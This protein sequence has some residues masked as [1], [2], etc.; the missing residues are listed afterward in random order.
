M[1]QLQKTKK[2]SNLILYS[3][4]RLIIRKYNFYKYII[5]CFK[6]LIY[7]IFI[8]NLYTSNSYFYSIIFVI[9]NKTNNK[10]SMLNTLLVYINLIL[11]VIYLFLIK[12][13]A[14]FE[15]FYP[16]LSFF[17]TTI[18]IKKTFYIK[19]KTISTK[20]DHDC[21]LSIIILKNII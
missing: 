20:T 18:P 7:Q 19:Y 6:Y 15:I 10:I 5:S 9:D 8:Y 13:Y 3:Q 1:V 12:Q 2:I 16:Q 21:L 4:F 14:R 17:K 11:P